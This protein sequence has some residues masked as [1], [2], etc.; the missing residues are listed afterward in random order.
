M[1]TEPIWARCLAAL[2]RSMSP[3]DQLLCSSRRGPGLSARGRHFS[4][5]HQAAKFAG[6]QARAHQD[7][8]PHAARLAES[9][10][11]DAPQ[12]EALTQA[13]DMLGS[14]DYLAPEQASDASSIDGRADIYSL[15]CTMFHLLSGRPPFTGKNLMDKLLAH[16]STPVPS[17]TALRSDVPRRTRSNRGQNDGQEPGRTLP[18]GEGDHRPPAKNR[19]Q[20]CG[21]RWVL[22]RDFEQTA[23][24]AVVGN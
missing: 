1:S 15:G 11:H 5:Q 14:A 7:R 10:D 13:G 23:A 16:R 22:Y 18:I 3:R 21:G 20:W 2:A 4:S 8:Q 19:P 6:R 24:E 12:E 9:G 17:L